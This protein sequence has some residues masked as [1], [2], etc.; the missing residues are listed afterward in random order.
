MKL[1]NQNSLDNYTRLIEICRCLKKHPK[2][3]NY[4]NLKDRKEK[5]LSE[6]TSL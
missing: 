2:V 4:L 5:K 1:F 3:V 6:D